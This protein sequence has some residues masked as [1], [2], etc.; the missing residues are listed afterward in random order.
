M[1]S[2]CERISKRSWTSQEVADGD[3]LSGE[4]EASPLPH[5]R[6]CRMR[7]VRRRLSAA[8]IS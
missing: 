3:G 8:A 4:R 7:T 5:S 1:P 6:R 2:L